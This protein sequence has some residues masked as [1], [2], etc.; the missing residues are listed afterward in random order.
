[1]AALDPIN[2]SPGQDNLGDVYDKI[3]AIIA[4]VNN[5][6][7]GTADQIFKQTDSTDFNFEACNSLLP[8][9][10]IG[11]RKYAEVEI[12]D[13]NMDTDTF[14]AVTI[15]VTLDKVK[16][17]QVWITPD[18]GLHMPLNCAHINSGGDCFSHPTDTE[19]QGGIDFSSSCAETIVLY[20]KPSGLFDSSDFA[21][22]PFNRGIVTIIYEE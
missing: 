10:G 8:A 21:T 7:P 5:L 22:T 13:W 11:N 12:G 2:Y 4:A 6:R 14:K 3:N 18:S 1:M 20:R 16:M 19:Q 15:P 9:T 17:V